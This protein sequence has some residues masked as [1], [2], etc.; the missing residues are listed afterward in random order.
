M[1]GPACTHEGLSF[2]TRS[3]ALPRPPRFRVLALLR[4]GGVLEQELDELAVVQRAVAVGVQ[5]FYQRFDLPLRGLIRAPDV[6]HDPRE[7]LPRNQAVAVLVPDP[8]HGLD[9]VLLALQGPLDRGLD[10]GRRRGAHDPVRKLVVV[11]LAVAVLVDSQ[12][13]QVDVRL[14]HVG[15]DPAEHAPELRPAQEAVLVGVRVL[16]G[17]HQDL[18]PPVK[19]QRRKAAH[20]LLQQRTFGGIVEE[21]R[22]GFGS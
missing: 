12:Q 6:L 11:D 18:L 3:T 20:D 14:S 9:Y 1:R 8:E 13:H 2:Q 17:G 7:L 19:R 4:L 16:E 22:Q 5:L 21:D 15:D 10:I